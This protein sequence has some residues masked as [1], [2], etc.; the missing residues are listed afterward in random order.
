M[1]R[2][3]CFILL[4]AVSSF[5]PQTEFIPHLYYP[6]SLD[7]YLLSNW[8]I[9]KWDSV[10]WENYFYY[11]YYYNPANILIEINSKQWDDSNSVWINNSRN[12][13]YY[14]SSG[15][16][17]EYFTQIWSNNSYKNHSK[18]TYNYN[19]FD[20]LSIF[21]T[22]L[23]D[24][25][26][27]SWNNTDK[28]MNEY[29]SNNYLIETVYYKG[30]GTNWNI[31]S[32]SI[33]TYDSVYNLILNLYQGWQAQWE[34]LNRTLYY[35]DDNKLSQYIWQQWI[36][37]SWESDH[38][39]S[40]T[41]DA[42]N[43]LTERLVETAVGSGWI[44]LLRDVRSYNQL[45]QLYSILTY[46]W[47]TNSW[48]MDRSV[49]YNYDSFGN[50]I[51]YIIKHWLD[52]N[53][54]EYQW[55][56]NYNYLPVYVSDYYSEIEVFTLSNVYPNPFNPITTIEFY[57]PKS[58]YVTLKIYDI[59][60]NEIATLVNEEKRAGNYKINF[61]AKELSAGVYFYRLQTGEFVETKKMVLIK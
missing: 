55:R 4:L 10:N 6:H 20:S 5:Y 28:T 56:V 9:Q 46:Y 19:S 45:N 39:E 33:F 7:N 16:H 17:Q 51:E 29:D 34:N 18:Q 15:R 22:F 31:Y 37:N 43:N 42:N 12:F 27:N 47:I 23:W 8:S 13:L 57:I 41:Y 35:Y 24:D 25:T 59:V 21:Q 36:N 48:V 44:N 58:S 49:D 38:R 3:F 60:G 40:F 61:N 50:I 1:K 52:N 26:T 11:E 32:R 30:S 53:T 2:I 14:D 54:W